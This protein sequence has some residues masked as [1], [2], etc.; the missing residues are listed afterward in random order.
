[1]ILCNAFG[2][3]GKVVINHC[4]FLHFMSHQNTIGQ[5]LAI[6]N[7]NQN[8]KKI[9]L[10][11]P[12]R[13]VGF[14]FFCFIVFFFFLASTQLC[15][16]KRSHFIKFSNRFIEFISILPYLVHISHQSRSANIKK[17]RWVCYDF[18][19]KEIRLK[20]IN[21]MRLKFLSSHWTHQNAKWCELNIVHCN[22]QCVQQACISTNL[23]FNFIGLHCILRLF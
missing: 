6:L 15:I 7:N 18:M 14:W 5:T 17:E 19:K 10:F 13:K 4:N 2:N 11:I 12:N 22:L 20:Q 23:T 16:L 8:W 21:S 9:E 1:M 3:K